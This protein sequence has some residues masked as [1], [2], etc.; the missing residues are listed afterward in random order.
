MLSF[1]AVAVL[2]AVA[3]G[4]LAAAVELGV[5]QVAPWGGELVAVADNVAEDAG[6]FTGS[7]GAAAGARA[8]PLSDEERGH[9]FEGIMRIR[10]VPETSVPWP[11]TAMPGGIALQ[12]LPASVTRDIPMVQGYKFVKLDDRIL[13]V[14]PLDRSV[15]AVMPRYKLILD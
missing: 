6:D 1:R 5:G 8:L 7:I 10:G 3:G 9:I 2:L 13:L 11:A 15:V 12:D 14:S 4:S